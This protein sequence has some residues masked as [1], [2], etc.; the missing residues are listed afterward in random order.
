VDAEC[1]AVWLVLPRFLARHLWRVWEAVAVATEVPN[2]PPPRVAVPERTV[3]RWRGR[4]LCAAL[5]LVQVL[6]TGDAL[7]AEL[8]TEV[9]VHACRL[10]LVATY[11]AHCGSSHPLADL[12]ALTHRLSPGVRLM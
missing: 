3:R 6:A 8:A 5:L 12:A 1:L 4:L 9:G 11:V 2:A 10:D 7:L